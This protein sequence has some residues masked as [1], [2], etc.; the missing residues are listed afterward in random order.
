MGLNHATSHL[1][2]KHKLNGTKVDEL[3][4][5]G[6]KKG[7]I[8]FLNGEVT[9][10]QSPWEAKGLKDP[11]ITT[12]PSSKK[13]PSLTKSDSQ[14]K[15]LRKFD[16]F[17]VSPEAS[18]VDDNKATPN[19]RLRSNHVVN[20]NLDDLEDL[21]KPSSKKRS[22]KV[23]A[24]HKV[25]LP[26]H[27]TPI[28]PPSPAQS[29]NFE[30]D[31][32][33]PNEQDE[34]DEQDMQEVH[35]E[36]EQQDQQEQE[37]FHISMMQPSETL[38]L[39]PQTAQEPPQPVSQGMKATQQLPIE[40]DLDELS[41]MS[42]DMDC[43]ESNNNIICNLATPPLSPKLSDD[44][45]ID[46]LQ[47]LDSLWTQQINYTQRKESLIDNDVLNSLSYVESIRAAARQ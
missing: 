6:S 43:V 25:D 15:K 33:E 20:I 18:D 45:S 38:P 8:Y 17:P 4:K 36:Q 39:A 10:H 21:P 24:I 46:A 28:T 12:P 35:D 42:H 5:P 1:I 7:V 29:D 31:E 16:A 3:I 14:L 37:D 41:P 19:R 44:I 34:H 26:V 11:Y 30:Q 47:E 9:G 2:R 22:P 27:E 23:D 40:Q 13:R 32:E